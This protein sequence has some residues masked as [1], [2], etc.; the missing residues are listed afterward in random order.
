[1]FGCCAVDQASAYLVANVYSI[2]FQGL[3]QSCPFGNG[4]FSA[5]FAWS[6]EYSNGGGTVSGSVT[7]PPTVRR[8]TD[9]PTVTIQDNTDPAKVAQFMANYPGNVGGYFFPGESPNCAAQRT[10]VGQYPLTDPTFTREYR[11]QM[12]IA[13]ITV[14]KAAVKAALLTQKFDS[15]P[16]YKNSFIFD[17]TG[18]RDDTFP[19]TGGVNYPRADSSF[20][21][22][23]G[24]VSFWHHNDPQ[25]VSGL[26]ETG[27]FAPNWQQWFT[28]YG[29]DYAGYTAAQALHKPPEPNIQ[30][31]IMWR[32]MVL[33]LYRNP[34]LA[35]LC[36]TVS[37]HPGLISFC[38]GGIRDAEALVDLACAEP[39][40]VSESGQI[41]LVGEA[42]RPACCNI[43]P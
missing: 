26:P 18:T 25:P 6:L 8:R 30:V 5:S 1:M 12:S 39:Y 23:G 19:T 11:A 13:F 10:H 33:S 34:T 41:Y 31:G 22:S 35:S 16:S 7:L 38:Q 15:A 21:S 29:G 20:R 27:G 9:G 17:R 4:E 24:K 2:G 32:Y 28:A 36:R 3:G 37:P 40:N 43:A 42:N 14:D